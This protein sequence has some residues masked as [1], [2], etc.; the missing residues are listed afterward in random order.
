MSMV[1]KPPLGVAPK[2]FHQEHR[3]GEL[4]EAVVRYRQEAVSIP[5]EWLEE[6]RDLSGEILARSQTRARGKP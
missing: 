3:L 5:D 6:I 2:W 1:K 4:C